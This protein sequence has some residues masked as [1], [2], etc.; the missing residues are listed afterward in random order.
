M[1]GKCKGK[2]AAPRPRITG[3]VAERVWNVPI[4]AW[5]GVGVGEV[6]S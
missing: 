6:R 4:R 2:K 3:P 1:E 5:A